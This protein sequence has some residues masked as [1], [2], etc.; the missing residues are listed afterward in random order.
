[1]NVKGYVDRES[2]GWVKWM[3]RLN[4]GINYEPA[5]IRDVIRKYKGDALSR[6]TMPAYVIFISD[7]GV[8]SNHEVERLLVE[9]SKLPI[10]WQFVGVGGSNYGILER[11]DT[12]SGRYIDNCNF[13]SLDD[14]HKVS[15]EVLYERLLNEFPAWLE[16][17]R[18][19]GIIC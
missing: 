14:L 6:N 8:G 5:V 18:S 10:F 1:M 15:D 19:K 2:G 3:Q 16:L 4:A 12:M 9:A 13:F 7:G 11:L 17:A